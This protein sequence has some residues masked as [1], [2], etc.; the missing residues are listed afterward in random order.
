[1]ATKPFG[2]V[3]VRVRDRDRD[4]D[5]DREEACVKSFVVAVPLAL[6][7]TVMRRTILCAHKFCSISFASS[8]IA[9]IAPNCFVYKRISFV[10]LNSLAV[11][12]TVPC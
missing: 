8:M 5:R 10:V 6:G 9:C 4:R 12:R 7:L 1:V 11:R 3:R 2:Q